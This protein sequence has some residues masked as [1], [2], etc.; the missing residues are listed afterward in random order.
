MKQK[1]LKKCKLVTF[2][3]EY[4]NLILYIFKDIN[5]KAKELFFII[6]EKQSTQILMSGSPRNMHFWISGTCTAS[7][8]YPL[9]LLHEEVKSKYWQPEW[10]TNLQNRFDFMD[11]RY[12]WQAIQFVSHWWSEHSLGPEGGE[13]G[14][15]NAKLNFNASNVASGRLKKYSS[16]DSVHTYFLTGDKLFN[17]KIPRGRQKF[18][19]VQSSLFINA[20]DL[21]S[22]HKEF[23]YFTPI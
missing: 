13:M 8:F 19:Y 3:D 23:Q 12:I 18:T 9:I 17:S 16:A 22:C 11:L 6:A 20:V 2:K 15:K 5:L 10:S 21:C 7:V 4:K 14:W 1:C